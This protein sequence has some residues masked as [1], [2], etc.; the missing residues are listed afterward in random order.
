MSGGGRILAMIV[1]ELW[2]VLR[3]PRGRIT[4]I[5]PPLLQLVL[6]SAAATL[7]VKN[8]TIG[9]YDRDGGPAATEF[10]NQLA[11]SPNVQRLIRIES[12]DALRRAID[13]QRA[14]GVL[15]F[16]Q[17][18]SSDV[19]AHRPAQVQ[20][21]FDGRRSNAA[22]ITASYIDQIAASVG[23]VVRPAASRTPPPGRV[24][25]SNWFN[26]N[27]D[28]LWFIM[29][30]L[31]AIICAISALSVI[32]QSVAREREL[33]TFDQLMVSPLRLHEI[34]IGKMTPPFL[35]GMFNGTLYLIVI[36]VFFGVPMTGSILLFYAA[37]TFFLLAVIG[38]GM[39]V[40][41]ISQ[42]QQQA[43][44]GMFLVTVPM[45]LLS[46]FTSP[47]ENMPRWLQ[48]IA[49]A[50]PQKH[51]LIIAEGLFLK[52]MPLADVFANSWPLM[53]I[54]AVTL[55]AATLQFRSRVE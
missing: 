33:G 44:L 51:F 28:Y 34:L 47:Y 21:I 23:A 38:I 19:A 4:L 1:K 5:I 39:V 3:D 12:P 41:T 27:L 37:L 49:E 6:F 53:V 36:P 10:I 55:T 54:A 15:V 50:N 18:F 31:V 42:S 25:V 40:S 35:I 17:R 52:A 43:F 20:A 7:E 30:S 2:A 29:P 45:T 11:G 13:D 22:Q 16:D 9:V 32:V 46:G 8:V 14:I 26:P 24:L 48:I